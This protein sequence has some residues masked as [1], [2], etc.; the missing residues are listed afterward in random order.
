METEQKEY[1]IVKYFSQEIKVFADKIVFKGVVLPLST[2][3]DIKT[4]LED[5]NVKL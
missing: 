5:F 4:A 3:R 1:V 2:L